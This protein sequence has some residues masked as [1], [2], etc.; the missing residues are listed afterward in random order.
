MDKDD[1]TETL[2]NMVLD[3]IDDIILIHDSEYT[4]VWMNRAGLKEFGVQ[5]EDVLGKRCYT[6][7]GKNTVCRDCNVSTMHGDVGESVVRIIPRTGEMYMC[8]SL[9]LY[10]NGKVTMVVQHL[11]KCKD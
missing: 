7:F 9:P 4:L 5:L 6:L 8:R 11:T 10:R 2:L 1:Y 3:E